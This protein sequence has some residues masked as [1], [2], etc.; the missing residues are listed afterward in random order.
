VARVILTKFVASLAF[1][2]AFSLEACWARLD[3]FRTVN[4]FFGEE[5]GVDDDSVMVKVVGVLWFFNDVP[6]KRMN[7]RMRG[8]AVSSI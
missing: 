7:G 3:A 5:E 8:C 6:K 4:C 1:D 2:F